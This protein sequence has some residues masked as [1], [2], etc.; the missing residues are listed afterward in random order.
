MEIDE[1]MWTH[2]DFLLVRAAGNNGADGFYSIQTESASKNALVVGAS[3]NLFQVSVD[4]SLCLV[5]VCCDTHLHMKPHTYTP[6]C[7]V[8]LERI[9]KSHSS[10]NI[11]KQDVASVW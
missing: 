1:F 3:E 5:Y 9:T 11:K 4:G 2:K 8:C 6:T 7:T 10:L